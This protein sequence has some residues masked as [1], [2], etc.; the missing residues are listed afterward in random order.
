MALF[1][2]LPHLSEQAEEEMLKS[3]S[4]GERAFTAGRYAISRRTGAPP[5]GNHVAC[6][7]LTTFQVDLNGVI[8]PG[9]FSE[10]ALRSIR[11]HGML[12]SYQPWARC[13]EPLLAY[14]P[15]IKRINPGL[16]LRIYLDRNLEFLA[17]RL[18]EWFEVHVMEESSPERSPGCLWPL[19]GLEDH[20][21]A[22]T[23]VEVESFP[24]ILDKVSLT[25]AMV[26]DGLGM[27]RVPAGMEST[28]GE[29]SYVPVSGQYW[30]TTGRLAMGGL[31]LGFE[32]SLARGALQA[33]GWIPGDT[34]ERAI[35]GMSGERPLLREF[36]L[37]TC[38]YPR[39]AHL[40]VLSVLRN[41]PPP[42][43]LVPDI[44]FCTWM[45]G[46]STCSFE[47]INLLDDSREGR[48][49]PA[50]LRAIRANEKEPAFYRMQIPA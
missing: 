11:C 25:E 36:F 9:G 46:E 10:K 49:L 4:E 20:P 22:F 30:G 47:L 34:K 33:T 41:E 23:H 45:S 26:Q 32:A 15:V 12:A 27:W 16:S 44:E 7:A 43:L 35:Y 5:S 6:M 39:L 17:D 28:A 24:S 18:G 2:H 13:I 48:L 3:V 14:G 8:P 1:D 42:R 21:G 37:M 38:V 40:G 50:A 31:L 29:I 19:L